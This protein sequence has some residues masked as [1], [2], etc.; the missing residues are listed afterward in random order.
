MIVKDNFALQNLAERWTE[1]T[2]K[3][4]AKI[5]K[6]GLTIGSTSA[7]ILAIPLT[8][9]VI[10]PAGLITAAGYGLTVGAVTTILAK[11]TSA[12]RNANASN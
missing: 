10:L 8:G 4:W 12:E 5:L 1:K 2:P 7:A 6:L 3:F 11:L 9:G